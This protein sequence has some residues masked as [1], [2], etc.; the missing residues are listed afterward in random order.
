LLELR[1]PKRTNVGPTEQVYHFPLEVLGAQDCP[2]IQSLF[3]TNVSIET[4]LYIYAALQ[5]SGHFICTVF[6]SGLLLNCFILE[7]LA[8]ITCS[9]VAALG[10]SVILSKNK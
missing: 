7:D 5:N 8:L 3:L 9:G 2:F 1:W 10:I 4:P 6:R